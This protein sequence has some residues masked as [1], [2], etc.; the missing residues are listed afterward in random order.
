MYVVR[1]VLSGRFKSR[2]FPIHLLTG[3]RRFQNSA[4]HIVLC[5]VKESNKYSTIIYL[6]DH[7]MTHIV[8]GSC[9]ADACQWGHVIRYQRQCSLLLVIYNMYNSASFT[10]QWHQPPL[11]GPAF[12]MHLYGVKIH[13]IMLAGSRTTYALNRIMHLNDMHLS[14]M[15]SY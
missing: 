2:F 1:F 6:L 7:V 11:L 5:I 12:I 14:K 8:L 9:S 4:T 13:R 3:R 15:T 10:V